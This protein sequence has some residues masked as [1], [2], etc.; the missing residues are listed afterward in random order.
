[1]TGFYWRAVER[2]GEGL[3]WEYI[4]AINSIRAGFDRLSRFDFSRHLG[5]EEVRTLCG[6]V[7]YRRDSSLPEWVNGILLGASVGT[8]IAIGAQKFHWD[9]SNTRATLD[10]RKDR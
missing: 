3:D 5:T 6:A 4:L 8:P 2:R 7:G 1:V 10:G 9:D